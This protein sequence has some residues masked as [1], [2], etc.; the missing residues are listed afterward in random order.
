MTSH[1]GH[2]RLGIESETYL[3]RT[4]PLRPAWQ[5]PAGLPQAA[6]EHWAYLLDDT[7]IIYGPGWWPFY[8][9][10]DWPS[11]GHAGVRR[12]AR[13]GCRVLRLAHGEAQQRRPREPRG[14][15]T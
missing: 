14:P 2:S 11:T 15:A 9:E 1:R 7:G 6:D 3:M 13:A 5:L 12:A 10:P 8:G 4:Q